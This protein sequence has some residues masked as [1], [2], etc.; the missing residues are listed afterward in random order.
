MGSKKVEQKKHV[1]DRV[2]IK[3]QI[4]DACKWI[5]GNALFSVFLI[6]MI[7]IMARHSVSAGFTFVWDHP[8]LVL[9]STLLLDCLYSLALLCPKRRFLWLCIT[10][11]LLTLAATNAILLCFR[12]TPL[13]ATDLTLLFSVVEIMGIY[14]AKWQ[15][16]G[17]ILLV[18]VLVAGLVF[19]GIK[20]P[21]GRVYPATGAGSIAVLFAAAVLVTELGDTLGVLPT[22]FSNLPDAYQDNGFVYCFSRSL[23]DR[24]I[25]K[26]RQYSEEAIDDILEAIKSEETKIPAF[27][28]NVIFLQIES[29]IDLER[30]KGVTYSDPPQPIYSSLRKSCQTGYLTVPSVGAGTA[31]TEFEIISGMNLDYFGAGEYPYKTV[32]QEKTCESMAYN[33]KENGYFCTAIHNNTGDFY[34]RNEVFA[35]LGFDAFISSEYMKN[36]TYNEMGWCHD[37]VLT[38][39]IL[40]ALAQNE[41]RDF[42]YAITVQDHGKYPTEPVENPHIRTEGFAPDDEGRQNAFCYYVNQCHETDAFLGYLISALDAYREPVVLV[43]FGD[44]LPNLELSE[45]ELSDGNCF[46]T[47][48]VIWENKEMNKTRRLSIENED[49]SA[50]QLSACLLEKLRMNNGV[51]TKFHQQYGNQAGYEENLKTL[52]YDMLYGEQEVFGGE[53]GYETADMQ[54]GVLPIR[55][56]Q[57]SGVGGSVYVQGENFTQSSTVFQNGKRRETTFLNENMLMVSDEEVSEGDSFTVAQTTELGMKL[58]ETDAYIWGAD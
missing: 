13:A 5:F 15:I 36:L 49:L 10:A 35:N 45:E 40:N 39:Q 38:Q 44:H 41:K 32:L 19:L 26:P 24:G 23:L 27:C 53:N 58:S 51:L 55:I 34:D 48:Y 22:S 4:E 42:I 54:M 14:F 9:Y 8:L 30:I 47:E 11:L 17:L 7:E 1:T 52:Q 43:M 56:T 16:I 6:L 28:P 37:S 18:A 20:M 31:N 46:Q 12:I 3:I 50:Y 29:F 21:A 25:N 2:Q 33:L 57:V